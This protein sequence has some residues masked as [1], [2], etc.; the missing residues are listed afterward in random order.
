MQPYTTDE[1]AMNF[2]TRTRVKSES[3]VAL[4]ERFYRTVVD[5]EPE[6]DAQKSA[7]ASSFRLRSTSPNVRAGWR[8]RSA[9]KARLIVTAVSHYRIDRPT[10][11]GRTGKQS[12]QLL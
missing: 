7:A 1:V 3:E 10:A 5:G 2:L 6:R 11:G 9:G 4:A 12:Q 8:N